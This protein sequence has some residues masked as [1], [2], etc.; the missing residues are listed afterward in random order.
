M[1]VFEVS[2]GILGLK[3]FDRESAIDFLDRGLPVI[4]VWLDL[5]RQKLHEN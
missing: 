5:I 2:E 1:L 3:D 4:P